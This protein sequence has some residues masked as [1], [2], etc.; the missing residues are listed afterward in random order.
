VQGCLDEKICQ[1]K[2]VSFIK[3]FRVVSQKYR[4][5]GGR[6]TDINEFFKCY[7]T[8]GGQK[9]RK[10]ATNTYN[11]GRSRKKRQERREE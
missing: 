10:K 5:K 7:R 3:F 4:K 11:S 2:L 9:H 8:M 6:A 1:G